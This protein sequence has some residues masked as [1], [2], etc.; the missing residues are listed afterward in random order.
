MVY[1]VLDE[2][3]NADAPTVSCLRARICVLKDTKEILF[4]EAR[5]SIPWSAA[6]GRRFA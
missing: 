4:W 2:V 3:V 1:L 5:G 6:V